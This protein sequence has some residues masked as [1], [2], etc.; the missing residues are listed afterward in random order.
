MRVQG[1]FFEAQTRSE[2]QLQYIYNS[3]NCLRSLR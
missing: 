3:E 1:V 2:E